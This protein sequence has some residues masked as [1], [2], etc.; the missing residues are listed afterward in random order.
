MAE[1]SD[2]ALNGRRYGSPPLVGYSSG[3]KSYEV[4]TT[5][6]VSALVDGVVE[7]LVSV[8]ETKWLTFLAYA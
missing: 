1:A 2:T 5:V 6:I 4:T 3:G 7:P 8:E